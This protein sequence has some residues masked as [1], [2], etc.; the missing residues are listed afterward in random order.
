VWQYNTAHHALHTSTINLFAATGAD[1][2]RQNGAGCPARTAGA[3]ATSPRV[4]LHPHVLL[5]IR[6]ERGAT[7]AGVLTV[8][9][10]Q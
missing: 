9:H 10:V 2:I 8:D 1:Q 7:R 3:G 6:A 5:L 4:R